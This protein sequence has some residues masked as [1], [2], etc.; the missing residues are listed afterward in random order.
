MFTPKLIR[1]AG[2]ADLGEFQLHAQRRQHRQKFAGAGLGQFSAL[3]AGQGFLG[4]TRAGGY[5]LL[6][7]A[8]VASPRRS[9]FSEFQDSMH[10]LHTSKR[11]D[12]VRLFDIYV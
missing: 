7:Q 8:E 6:L 10:L 2:C 5:A 12:Y 1:C 4:N 9:G 3:E 11:M